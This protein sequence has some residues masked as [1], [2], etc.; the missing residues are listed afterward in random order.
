M[1]TLICR[2]KGYLSEQVW[3][4][5]IIK[6]IA[7][8]KANH[9]IIEVNWLKN[10]PRDNWYA[11]PFILK[12]DDNNIE[13]LAEEYIS[14]DAKGVISLLT[15]DTKTF[16]V[17]QTS[18]VLELDTHLSFP[19]IYRNNGKTYVMPE[20]YQ[21]GH[22]TLYEY[23]DST[24]QL[25]NP[26][27]ILNESVVDSSIVKI[28]DCYYLFTT[29]YSQEFCGGSQDL[30]IYRSENIIGPYHPHQVISLDTPI[31]RGAGSVIKDGNDY[32]IP[33]QNCS[34]GYGKQV[35]INKLSMHNNVFSIYEISRIS[36]L[37]PYNK[38]CHTYN[39]FGEYAVIDGYRYRYGMVSD[40]MSYIY[41]TLI[42]R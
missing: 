9:Y 33:T 35:I 8:G 41:N 27:I 19:L 5:G 18:R 7:L 31:A 28:N 37:S 13:I 25:V 32:Y 17:K 24:Q 26:K 36:P 22:L 16:R 38:G 14:K 39:I 42:K 20:N 4:I 2:L 34:A 40:F 15:I 1:R 23:N 21:A 3:N 10:I 6:P 29:K 11:D 30:L 12:Y